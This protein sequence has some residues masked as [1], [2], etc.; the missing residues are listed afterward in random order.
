MEGT[1][2][3]PFINVNKK[4]ARFEKAWM[5]HVLIREFFSAQI[6]KLISDTLLASK[7]GNSSPL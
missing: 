7:Q 5:G 1:S 2:I 6:T 3:Y 4:I